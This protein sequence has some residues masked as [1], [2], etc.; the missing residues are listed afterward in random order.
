MRIPSCLWMSLFVLLVVAFA[1]CAVTPEDSLDTWLDLQEMVAVRLNPDGGSENWRVGPPVG[2]VVPG[3]GWITRPKTSAVICAVEFDESD[4]LVTSRQSLVEITSQK[5]L[6]LDAD[7]RGRLVRALKIASA[8]ASLVIGPRLH[9]KYEDLKL[10]QISEIG[11]RAALETPEVVKALLPYKGRKLPIV[12]GRF[13]G[14]VTVTYGTGFDGSLDVSHSDAAGLKLSYVSKE[15]FKLEGESSEGWFVA[16]G[17]VTLNEAEVPELRSMLKSA[18]ARI[19]ERGLRE[20]FRSRELVPLFSDVSA[21]LKDLNRSGAG[22][23]GLPRGLDGVYR[24]ETMPPPTLE[25]IRI[26]HAFRGK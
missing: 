14:K 17:T 1:G 2:L 7:A 10:T 8:K 23:K 11:L 18:P 21:V 20:F 4:L 22:T 26:M 19:D 24:V 9:L 16:Y 5:Q 3:I 12:R 15:G 25:E 13:S 6:K